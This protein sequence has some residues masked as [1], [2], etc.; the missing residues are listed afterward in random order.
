VKIICTTVVRAAKQGDIHGGLYVIDTESGTVLHHAPYEKDFINDNERGGERGLRGIIVL[1]DRIIVSDSAGFIELDKN[2]Y[3]IKRTFQDREYFKSI[4]E[5]AFFDDHIWATST[6][7]DAVV[8]LDLDFNIKGFWEIVGKDVDNHK[9]LTGKVETSPETKSENDS[10]HINS[11][12]A[13]KDRLL[14]SGLLTPLYDFNTFEEVCE[15]PTIQT[16]SGQLSNGFIHNFYGYE[17]FFTINFTTFSSLG[18][19]SNGKDFEHFGIPRSSNVKYQVDEIASNNWNRGLARSEGKL[20][21]GSSPARI[22]VF[23][24]EK[25]TFEAEITLENDIRHAIH[26]LEVIE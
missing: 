19:S 20:F 3:E 14:F 16:T 25:K 9:I 12:F 10:Y 7:Y 17:D 26:G 2:T 1:D 5:I 15:M 13:T 11:I 8:K 24:I 23:D 6:A 18:I 21:I 22:L 4:H